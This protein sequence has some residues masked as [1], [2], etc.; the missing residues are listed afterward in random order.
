MNHLGG[1]LCKVNA[2]KEDATFT[3]RREQ[4]ESHFIDC[5][6]KNML[7]DSEEDLSYTDSH[8]VEI[9]NHGSVVYCDQSNEISMFKSV[10]P[11]DGVSLVMD[12]FEQSLDTGDDCTGV[13]VDYHDEPDI[14]EKRVLIDSVFFAC[15]PTNTGSVA[16]SDVITYLRDTLRVSNS[17]YA[18]ALLLHLEINLI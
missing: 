9:V 18:C 8:T 12:K 2:V 3:E 7:A 5:I 16:V 17:L 1:L 4:Y 14:A 11:A 15:D 6:N 13:I 10:K